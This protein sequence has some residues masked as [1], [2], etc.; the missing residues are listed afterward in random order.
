MSHSSQSTLTT[1]LEK[2]INATSFR[3]YGSLDFIIDDTGDIYIL[4]LNP[5][6]SASAELYSNNADI[7]R[8]HIESCIGKL[9]SELQR[10]HSQ[11]S[12]ISTLSYLFAET[13]VFV[14]SDAQW[15]EVAHD[16]PH[17]KQTIQPGE[18]ICTLLIQA[19][20][21]QDCDNK[22]LQLETEIMNN[23]LYSA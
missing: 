11:T 10:Q 14:K 22:R 23:C 21:Q 5:R 7:L 15:P 12:T 9:P 16:I 19:T 13:L 17:P 20:S 3:G 2:L 1:S 8:W 6:L 4:E 18:P